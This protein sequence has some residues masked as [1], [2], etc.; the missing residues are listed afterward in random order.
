MLA[1][2]RDVADLGRDFGSGLTE[3]ELMYLARHEWAKSGA[4]VLWRRS[5][6]GLHT[7]PQA[8]AQIDAFYAGLGHA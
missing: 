4:D 5:K 3:A 2:A 6:M 7:L 8:E 1:G